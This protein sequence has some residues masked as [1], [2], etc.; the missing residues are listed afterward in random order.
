MLQWLVAVECNILVG[1]GGL[2]VDFEGECAIRSTDDGYI[3]HVDSAF[4]LYFKG[5]LQG[6]VDAVKPCMERSE[7]L[8]VDRCEG[9]VGL[10]VPE[11]EDVLH[12]LVGVVGVVNS[13]SPAFVLSNFT[14]CCSSLRFGS[15]QICWLFSSSSSS[16]TYLSLQIF[17]LLMHENYVAFVKK[18]RSFLHQILFCK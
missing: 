12:H 9:V 11:L 3:K 18:T 14:L 15:V 4:T 1:V 10:A 2:P 17:S 6:R 8:C 5:P 13:G 16:L 7:V